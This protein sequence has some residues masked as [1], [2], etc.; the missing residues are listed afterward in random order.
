MD[1]F[2]GILKRRSIRK[3]KEKE[4]EE[5]ILKKI[6]EAGMYAPSS[7][8]KRP[9]FFILIKNKEILK[10]IADFHPYGKMLYQAPC[11]I[12][13]CGN[14][15]LQN[16]EGYLA[17]DCAAATQNILLSALSFGIGSCW[18]AVYPRE[19][20]INFIKNL[21]NL[22]KNLLPISL[23]SLGYPAEEKEK[24]ERFEEEK[25]KILL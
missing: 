1:L 14:K 8:N 16:L 15:N 17:L 19:E 24:P 25:L 11:A 3:Y 23:V 18:I 6:I 21:L 12:L 10:K 7:S 13:V 9:W 20:R 5:E 22:E 4:I 2:E